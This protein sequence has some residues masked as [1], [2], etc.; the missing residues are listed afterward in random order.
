MHL[1]LHFWSNL[2][3]LPFQP[4]A[5]KFK[6]ELKKKVSII[7]LYI[8]YP[9]LWIN[10][11]VVPLS[12]DSNWSMYIICVCVHITKKKLIYVYVYTCVIWEFQQLIFSTYRGPNFEKKITS[13][14]IRDAYI[15]AVLLV[16]RLKWSAA[17]LCVHPTYMY[18]AYGY[19]VHQVLN[20]SLV[21][22]LAI[23]CQEIIYLC[24]KNNVSLSANAH[25]W[26]TLLLF[27]TYTYMNT[28]SEC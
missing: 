16:H 12:N 15:W 4:W 27:I 6:L 11:S 28:I 25:V 17:L 3:W 10:Y 9:T 5:G 2:E 7:F 20:V 24:Y 18:M 14:S 8:N 1:T 21:V 23:S 22:W 26:L 13:W 19:F